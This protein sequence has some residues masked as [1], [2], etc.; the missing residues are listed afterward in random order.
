MV[1]TVKINLA[2]CEFLDCFG[3]RLLPLV[4][5]VRRLLKIERVLYRS[6]K[7]SHEENS[8]KVC[9]IKD[10]CNEGNRKKSAIPT[11]FSVTCFLRLYTLHISKHVPF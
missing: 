2:S 4:H 9:F 3:I 11:N 8:K 6:R 10:L 5:L 7:I 1:S